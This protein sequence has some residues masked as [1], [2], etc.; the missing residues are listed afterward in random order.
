MIMFN[1]TGLPRSCY[2]LRLS[3]R[4][5]GDA[6]IRCSIPRACMPL[7]R[8]PVCTWGVIK[9]DSPFYS[10]CTSLY[11]QEET[12]CLLDL[13]R[14]LTEVADAALADHPSSQALESVLCYFPHSNY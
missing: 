1:M 4:R 6:T 9:R 11:S 12:F 13:F 10:T 14:L 5:G 2:D 7:R 8:I 3:R